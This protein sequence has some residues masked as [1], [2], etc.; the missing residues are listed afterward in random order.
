MSILKG[1]VIG[2]LCLFL[3][4]SLAVF[5]D[6]LMLKQTVLDPGFMNSQVDELDVSS[7]AEELIIERIHAE[8]LPQGEEFI[9]DVVSSTIIDLEPWMTEQKSTI[10]YSVYGYLNGESENMTIAIPLQPVRNSL[11]ENIEEVILQSPP[12]ELEGAPQTL[13]DQIIN[14]ANEMIDQE[15]PETLELNEDLWGPE[16][17]NTLDVTKQ[18]VGY[19]EIGYMVL[20]GVIVLLTLCLLLI[21][22]PIRRALR[23]VG[24]VFLAY[25]VLQYIGIIII[26][27]VTEKQIVQAEMPVALYNWLPQFLNDLFFT[28]EMF[29]IGVAVAGLVLLIAGIIPW[30][31]RSQFKQHAS[32]AQ[33]PWVTEEQP[34][35]VEQQSPPVQQPPVMEQRPPVFQQQPPVTQQVVICPR[36]GAQCSPDQ[37]FCSNCG[38]MMFQQQYVC[39]RCGAVI[40]PS[41]RFCTNCGG[42][43]G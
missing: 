27:R 22:K 23:S 8:Q 3:F 43:F 38:D 37:R 10:I 5:G 34:P 26:T 33:R 6:F 32:T 25:G 39:P 41:A 2:L 19:I 28:L 40:D 11:K 31:G 42:M 29:S 20:I 1:F 18:V 9:D 21:I 12:P 4:F 24:I 7:V 35:V 14:T 17:Q 16:F 30:S 13:I 15:I 36:C